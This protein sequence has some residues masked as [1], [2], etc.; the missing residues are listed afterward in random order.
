[1]KGTLRNPNAYLVESLQ[2]NP[3]E[4]FIFKSARSA[5]LDPDDKQMKNWRSPSCSFQ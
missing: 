3:L 4:T 1:M 2:N 5:T